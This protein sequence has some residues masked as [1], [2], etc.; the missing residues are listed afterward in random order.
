MT[1]TQRA[2]RFFALAEEAEKGQSPQTDPHEWT[3]GQ[4]MAASLREIGRTACA[5]DCETHNKGEM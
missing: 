5:A 2:E 1:P 3:L 4:A